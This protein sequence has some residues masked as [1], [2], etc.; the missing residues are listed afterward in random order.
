MEK[1]S[2]IIP[3]YN[4]KHFVTTAVKSAVVQTYPEK[5]ILVVD[6]NSAYD[7]AAVLQDFKED[8]VLIRNKKNIGYAATYNKGI[9]ASSGEYVTLL[10]D[11]DVF[12]PRKVERQMKVFHTNSSIGLVYC[13]IGMKMNNELLYTPVV[14]ERNYWRRLMHQNTIGITPLIRRECFS[15]CG[16]FDPSLGYHEDRDLWYRIGKR[17]RFGVAYEPSYI[18]Y[19]RGIHRLS[20]ELD[21]ICFAKHLLYEKHR[22]DF[23]DTRRYFSDLYYELGCTYLT[24]GYVRNFVKYFMKSFVLAP[25]FIDGTKQFHRQVLN[26]GCKR[27]KLDDECRDIFE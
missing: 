21:R 27:V 19:T 26:Y 18:M 20:S 16:V 14:E 3:T 6:D 17:F 23:R 10:N 15:V 13:P 7:V 24:F 8:I 4:R 22:H 5:E 11:D 1:V 12:H 9:Q 2:I 25:W